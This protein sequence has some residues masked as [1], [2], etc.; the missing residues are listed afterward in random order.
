LSYTREVPRQPNGPRL[1]PV[2]QALTGASRS[3]WRPVRHDRAARD[4]L[5]LHWT[6]DGPPVGVQ[7]VAAYG[8]E[9]VPVR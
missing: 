6:D 5:P 3:A 2:R 9:D 7:L 4:Q 1:S 8:R